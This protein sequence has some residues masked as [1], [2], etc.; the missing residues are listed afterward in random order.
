MEELT[1]EQRAALDAVKASRGSCPP[2]ETLVEYESLD[3]DARARHA[4]HDHISIC[5]RCQ[6]VLLHAA[7]PNA[8]TS[9]KLRWMLPLA[10]ALM[11]GVAVTMVFRSPVGTPAPVLEPTRG[12]ELRPVNPIGTVDT[13]T[14]FS[15]E[16][17]IRADVYSVRV[18]RG[19][20]PVW[21]GRT[22]LLRIEAPA[23]VFEAGV[24]YR[25][26][27]SALAGANPD[28]DVEVR[29]TSPSRAF[30]IRRAP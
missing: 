25:W 3:A 16:S 13:V 14:E 18:T 11:L 2:A 17:S 8:A 7:E 24:E 23:G 28:G 5:S 4:A 27:V 1:S 22:K 6:L 10:A 19:A 29:M 9:S 20:D 12:A 21:V 26:T 30:T 15:W